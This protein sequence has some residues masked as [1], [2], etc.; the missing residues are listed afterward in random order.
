M[1]AHTPHSTVTYGMVQFCFS[2]TNLCAL[3]KLPKLYKRIT[4]LTVTIF[5]FAF[6]CNIHFKSP[7]NISQFYHEAWNMRGVVFQK[8]GEVMHHPFLAASSHVF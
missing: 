6:F 1:E 4:K 2:E 7:G 5:F 8:Q 3:G